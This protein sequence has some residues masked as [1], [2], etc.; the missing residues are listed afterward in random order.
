MTSPTDLVDPRRLD[1]LWPRCFPHGVCQGQQVVAAR[2]E[3]RRVRCDP[4]YLPTARRDQP[5]RVFCAQVVAMRFGVRRKRP[6]DRRRVG[7]HIGQRRRRRTATGGPR[8]TTR[9]AH[10][11]TL[12]R[13]CR[14]TAPARQR[15]HSDP[16]SFLARAPR[17]SIPTVAPGPS[18]VPRS[19]S[20]SL[21]YAAQV[22]AV[23][24]ISVAVRPRSRPPAATGTGAESAGR[25]LRRERHWRAAGPSGS[26]SS[27]STW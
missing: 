4:D 14:A 25:W 23:D 10:G 21:H 12:A 26:T 20:S 11:R 18:L 1:W 13:V 3:A 19:G 22:W 7:V 15:S 6:Q 8:T 5:L 17:R 16:R 27:S 9:R 2:P 24:P